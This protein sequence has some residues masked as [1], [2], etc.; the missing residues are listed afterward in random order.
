[1]SNKCRVINY[2]CNI[3]VGCILQMAALQVEDNITH[4]QTTDK[5]LIK[6][7]KADNKKY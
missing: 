3:T 5:S 1:M 6:K 2:L 4:K 7:L